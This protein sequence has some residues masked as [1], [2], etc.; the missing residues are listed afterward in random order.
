M[1][2]STELVIGD[3]NGQ[4]VVIRALSRNH[5]A[6]FDYWDGNWV[7]CELDIAA[8]SF[9]GAFRADLRSEEFQAFLEEAEGLSRTLDGAASF[10]TMEGQIAFSLAGDASGHIRVQ[11]EAVDTPGGDNRLQFSFAIDQSYLPGICSS[12]EVIL[13][14]F[15]VVGTADAS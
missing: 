15:P 8:G 6:L 1:T 12:L 3:E 9:R 7:D 10:S 14:A 4:R 11:G 13:A 5:P 2:A